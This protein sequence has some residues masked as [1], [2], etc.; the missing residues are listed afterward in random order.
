MSNPIAER[1]TDGVAVTALTTPFWLPSLQKLSEFAGLVIP[2][3]GATWLLVQIF[4]YFFQLR[5]QK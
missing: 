2:I 1:I 5:K 4:G 3:L